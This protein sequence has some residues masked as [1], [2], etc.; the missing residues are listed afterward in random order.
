MLLYMCVGLGSVMLIIFIML[1]Y[2][3]PA[4]I[5]SWENMN[6]DLNLLFSIIDIYIL[7][8]FVLFILP[9]MFLLFSIKCIYWFNLFGEILRNANSIIMPLR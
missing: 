2:F 8:I 6:L 4:F 5:L 9:F 1:I 7:N 3:H